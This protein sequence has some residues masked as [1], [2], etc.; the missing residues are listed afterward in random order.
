V[1]RDEIKV[2]RKIG[3][4]AFGEVSLAS[5]F[6]FGHVAVKWL[7]AERF[8]KHSRTFMQE[9]QMMDGL[10]H[11]NVLAFYGVVVEST[12]GADVVRG[13]RALLPPACRIAASC[14]GCRVRQLCR[15][16]R[17]LRAAPRSLWQG[18]CSPPT[19]PRPA[20]PPALRR[21]AS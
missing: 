12:G 14:T 7:K 4:G 20:T 6:P 17:A 9:A 13:S 2:L 18:P 5:V 1:A 11:P 8:S 16:A 10:S 19:C 15:A 3:E 21:W